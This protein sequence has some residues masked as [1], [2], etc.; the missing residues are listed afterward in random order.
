MIEYLHLSP[1]S[2][3]HIQRRLDLVI[4]HLCLIAKWN[5]TH[6]ITQSQ[7]PVS[8]T[9]MTFPFSYFRHVPSLDNRK[10]II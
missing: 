10:N 7:H 3:R 8:F 2:R 6:Q 5:V 4:P 9:T 1:L